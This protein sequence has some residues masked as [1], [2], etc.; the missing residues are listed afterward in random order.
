MATLTTLA[1]YHMDYGDH[2]G[3]GSGWAISPEE[4]KERRAVLGGR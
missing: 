3:N 4:Y 1:Q 2:M